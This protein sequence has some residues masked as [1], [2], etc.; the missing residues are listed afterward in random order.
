MLSKKEERRSFGNGP[1]RDQWEKK[2]QSI[3]EQNK[4]EAEWRKKSSNKICFSK[5]NYHWSLVSNGDF[6]QLTSSADDAEKNK[7]KI[8]F[9]VVPPPP[10]PKHEPAPPPPTPRKTAS[11][12]P[13]RQKRKVEVDVFGLC[14]RD[15]WKS[16]KPPK[17]LYLKTK[18]TKTTIPG[19]TTIELTNNREYKPPGYGSEAEWESPAEKWSNSWKQVKSPAQLERTEENKFQWEIPI[20]RK[21]VGKA[22]IE[23][24]SLP[25]WAGTWKF[26]NFAFRQQQKYWDRIWPDFQQNPSN[27]FDKVHQLEE[28][29]EPSDWEDSWKLSEAELEPKDTTEYEAPT[30]GSSGT[31]TTVMMRL[32][33]V[34]LPGWRDSWLLS[35][36]PLEEEEERHKNWNSCWGFRQQIRWVGAE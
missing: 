13:C 29:D 23:V 10:K 1:L 35:A 25:V 8:K 31:D 26:I 33:E 28:Q 9:K 16:L 5:W 24:F 11:P 21:P 22:E 7:P 6:H 2:A 4:Q 30:A 15:S 18:E 36:A 19:F 17:Y 20:E 12:K 34:I 3:S 14:W 32:N 27:K